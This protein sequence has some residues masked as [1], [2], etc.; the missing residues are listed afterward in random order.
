MTSSSIVDFIK[1]ISFK[2]VHGVLK[3]LD[4]VYLATAWSIFLL[5]DLFLGHTCECELKLDNTLPILLML[6]HCIWLR[7]KND[8]SLVAIC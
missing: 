1:L 4:G 3:G 7:P 6:D 5:Q 8:V 2:A